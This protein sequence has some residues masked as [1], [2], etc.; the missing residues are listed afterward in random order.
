MPGLLLLSQPVALL[1]I[2]SL[3]RTFANIPVSSTETFVQNQAAALQ[4]RSS[5]Q[6]YSCHFIHEER[7]FI[8]IFLTFT[9]SNCIA[10]CFHMLI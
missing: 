7:V 10:Q 4:V 3:F 5:I 9:M 1:F 6:C 2:S 8:F